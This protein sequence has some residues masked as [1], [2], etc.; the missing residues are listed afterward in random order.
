ML[1]ANKQE[2]EYS[3][4]MGKRIEETFR[5]PMQVL[6][7]FKILRNPGITSK[8]LKNELNFP[9]T[10]IYYYLDYL[11]G[12]ERIKTKDNR[13]ERKQVSK[14]FI[15]YKTETTKNRLTRKKY[16]I[17]DW[18]KE[19]VNSRK[20]FSIYT[21]DAKNKLWQYFLGI[22][23]SIALMNQQLREIE[24]FLN[25]KDITSQDLLEKLESLPFSS[26]DFVSAST[27]KLFISRLKEIYDEICKLEP[28]E[29]L[30]EAMEKS[31]FAFI[32]GSTKNY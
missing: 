21:E 14:P 2:E 28:Q 17:T 26:L 12:I 27:A 32:I 20:F 15:E 13:V 23:I 25:N 1:T 24:Q 10:K 8:E 3:V 22:K 9:G 4:P 18:T 19:L 7:L 31:E 5:D 6:I 30:I 11:E 29:D 16:F